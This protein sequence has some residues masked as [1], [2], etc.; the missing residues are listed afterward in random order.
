M[1]VTALAGGVGGAKLLVGL[2]R[3]VPGP[4]LTAV[5]NTGDDAV[6]YGL[7][8]SPDVDIV[9]YWLA[10]VADL[11][12]GWGL[13]GDTFTVVESLRA[14][15]GD[16]WFSLG[17][18]DLAT[19]LYRTL[20]L[21]E[22]ATLSRVAAE[23]AARLGVGAAVL[24]MS[25]DPVRTTIE[26]SDGR[27]LGFQDYFVRERTAPE[28][29]GVTLA[30]LEEAVPAP[31]VLA[32]IESA[33]RVVLCPSNPVVSIGPILALSGVRAALAE[34]PCVVAV[35]PIVGGKAV[36]GPA[37]R[38]LASLGEQASA[39]G[40]ARRYRDVCD[41]FVLD[42]MDA[43]LAASID[44]LGPRAVTLDTLMGDHSSSERLAKEL[45]DL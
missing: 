4:D 25:D 45:I 23:V 9:T 31:G 6:V 8:V 2:Q 26:T 17:D 39:L 13:A 22:G 33:D 1:K 43:G 35:S 10:G 29:A 24:P 36:K 15:G 18:R 34:H 20:R 5:V 27:S 12:R 44:A 30:G 37:D 38:M 28:V 21:S 11:G 40:V 14:L 3:V 19:C 41:I 7:H 16:G 42:Q 32:A